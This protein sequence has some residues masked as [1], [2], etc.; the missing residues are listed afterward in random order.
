MQ[1]AVQ[2]AVQVALQLAPQLALQ[3]GQT[4]SPKTSLLASMSEC[5]TCNIGILK[6]DLSAAPGCGIGFLSFW[7]LYDMNHS[8]KI[9]F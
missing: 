5:E 3:L 1:V 6:V 2:V 8:M 9:H 7:I 4:S